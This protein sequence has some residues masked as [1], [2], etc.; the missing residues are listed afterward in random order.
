MYKKNMKQSAFIYQNA[1]LD[2]SC[3]VD[4]A[5]GT[6]ASLRHSKMQVILVLSIELVQQG[7]V[8]STRKTKTTRNT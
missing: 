4:Y 8:S 2:F 3:I 5:E 7:L 6:L 1:V